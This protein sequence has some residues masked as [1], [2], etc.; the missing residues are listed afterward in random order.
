MK[1]NIQVYVLSRDR[2]KYLEEALISIIKNKKY[3][4]FSIVV[5]DNSINND[6]EELIKEKYKSIKYLRR[7]PALSALDHF[8]V[9]LDEAS[10]E[11]LV[12]FHDDDM[13]MEDYVLKMKNVLDLNENIAAVGCNGYIFKK[14][15]KCNLLINGS[16]IKVISNQK[17]LLEAY[18][19]FGSK[20]IAPFPGYMYRRALIK[21][22]YLDPIDGGKYSDV[23][24]LS[25]IASRA[26]I[27]WINEPLI[28]YRI[29]E[30]NDS[31][32]D[33]IYDRLRLRRYM[34]KSVGYTKKSE[35]I[36][37]MKYQYL[38]AWI[39]KS[40]K[41]KGLKVLIQKREKIVLGFLLK[42]TLRMALTRKIFWTKLKDKYI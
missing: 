2:P 21:G 20:G 39:K 36:S 8:R 4:E 30:S 17:D 33:S 41:K 35:I 7:V 25:K 38:R 5:S 24:Y 23:S 32:V 14:N 6:V 13:M 16:G 31:N 10:E 22:I 27:V 15:K 42:Y 19:L 40:I 18:F 37:A 34:Q 1:S 11:Y 28:L 26:P 3:T 29:H 9:V 12:I